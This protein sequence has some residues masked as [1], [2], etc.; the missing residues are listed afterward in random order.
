MAKPL[1]D[2]KEKFDLSPRIDSRRPAPV[3]LPENEITSDALQPVEPA[4]AEAFDPA[5]LDADDMSSREKRIAKAAYRLAE[6]R[7][8]EPGRELDDWL[9]AEKEID[10]EPG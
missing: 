1:V 2:S 8:F 3:H 9:A 10:E 4:E 5:L 7:G 6:Q